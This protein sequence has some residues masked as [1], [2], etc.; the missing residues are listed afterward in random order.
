MKG[1]VWR[2]GLMESTWL[3]ELLPEPNNKPKC[4]SWAMGVDGLR[5]WIVSTKVINVTAAPGPRLVPG[6]P[7]LLTSPSPGL[8]FRRLQSVWR[9]GGRCQWQYSTWPRAQG[10]QLSS[11]FSDENLAHCKF[12]I[13]IVCSSFYCSPSEAEAEREPGQ[14]GAEAVSP[15]RAPWLGELSSDHQ[16]TRLETEPLISAHTDISRDTS[17]KLSEFT[18]ERLLWLWCQVKTGRSKLIAS[19]PWTSWPHAPA[20]CSGAPGPLQASVLKILRW[21]RWQR[22][23]YPG[24]GRAGCGAGRVQCNM[25]F[26][27]SSEYLDSLYLD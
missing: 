22:G 21:V 24:Q 23:H 27:H 6:G 14:C 16:Q 1:L 2:F 17:K 4:Y 8:G 26:L 7:G 15:G 3:I 25:F 12:D 5:I 11:A 9:D 18:V 13:C 10:S 19:L 20:A